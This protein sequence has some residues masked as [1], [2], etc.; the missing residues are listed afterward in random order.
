M[1]P[2]KLYLNFLSDICLN[3]KDTTRETELYRFTRNKSLKSNQMKNTGIVLSIGMALILSAFSLALGIQ[4]Q[5]KEGDYTI[6]FNTQR[7]SGTING[8]K[9]TISFDKKDLAG[10]HF[11]VTVDVHTL[12]TGLKMKNRHARAESFFNAE[13]YPTIRFVSS[14]ISNAG[15]QYLVKGKLTIK[16]ITKDV[17]I[18]FSFGEKGNEGVFK[19]EFEI[20]R[21]DYNL[22]K[23]GVGEIINIQLSVPVK[24]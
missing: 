13:K 9:G 11:D 6:R 8:L 12:D 1:I 21:T 23:K 2:L 5:I 7:A 15:D 18:P 10:S 19:G 17:E 14:K 24:K 3:L 20:N 4:W 22:N 16:D